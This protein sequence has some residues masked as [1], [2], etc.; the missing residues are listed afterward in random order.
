MAVLNAIIENKGSTLLID[1]PR[2]I[3][4]VYEKLLS[5]GIH[6][7]LNAIPLTDNEG[8]DI[9]VTLYSE[10]DFGNHVVR[11]FS[12]QHTLGDVNTL[13]M[14][15]RNSPGEIRDALEQGIL[16]DQ[17]DTPQALIADI[18]ERTAACGSVKA[19]F[20]CPLEGNLED[21]RCGDVQSVG[22]RYLR[23]YAW[24][25]R[26]LLEAEQA[27]PED[28]M[29]QFFNEDDGIKAKL[30]SAVWTVDEYQGRLFGRIDCRFRESLTE[31]E[32]E[33]FKDWLLGQCSDGFGEHFE[34]Q[35]IET[36]EGD[37]FVSFWNSGGDYF[38]CSKDELD[39]CIENFQRQNGG[40]C[41]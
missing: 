19:S 33:V 4:D 41:L 27:S 16:Q 18:R 20:F 7:N 6:Q 24:A 15:L 12:E 40:M 8:D 34:Q 37:L 38:L 17:Y 2:S 28:E 21:N 5:I 10:T 13:C 23:S 29:A 22:N 3:Y 26:D 35:P 30:V 32:T 39:E 9:R 14:V 11:L 31:S 1:F 25:I 36:E